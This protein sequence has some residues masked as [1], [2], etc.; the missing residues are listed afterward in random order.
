MSQ[1]KARGRRKA[2]RTTVREHFLTTS[3]AEIAHFQQNLEI[4][5]HVD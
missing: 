2:Q 5:L 1:I 4:L 3:N